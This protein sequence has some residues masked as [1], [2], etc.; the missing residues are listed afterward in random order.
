MGTGQIRTRGVFHVMGK[1]GTACLWDSAGGQLSIGPL[2][3]SELGEIPHACRLRFVGT[4]I[5]R[6][7]LIRAFEES[8]VTSAEFEDP[9]IAW[10]E[11]AAALDPWIPEDEDADN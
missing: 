6:A 1:P 7:A 8:L 5:D 4:G 2:A 9:T 3:P 10:R 11:L